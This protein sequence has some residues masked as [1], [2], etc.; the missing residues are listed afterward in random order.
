VLGRIYDAIEFRG[1][2]QQSAR[3]LVRFSGVPVYNGLTDEAHPTQALADF[4]TMRE[5]TH[6]H[7]SDMSVAFLGDVRNNVARSLAL[8]AMKLG[9]DLRLCGPGELHPEQEF[10]SKLLDISASTNAKLRVCDSPGEALPGAD[11]RGRLL[12]S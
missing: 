6:K 11:F 2:S 5:F 7:L 10:A 1:F 3:E 4:M 8:G 9:M 12:P